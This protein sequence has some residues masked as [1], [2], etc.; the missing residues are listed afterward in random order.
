MQRV[1]INKYLHYSFV[2][3][4]ALMLIHVTIYFIQTISAMSLFGESWESE[5][6]YCVTLML[7]FNAVLAVASLILLLKRVVAAIIALA[8]TVATITVCAYNQIG[9]EAI[10]RSVILVSILLVSRGFQ[11]Y[12]YASK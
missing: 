6:G 3:C 9:L 5:F 11:L 8:L 1:A 4:M 12:N 10:L 7:I 2:I